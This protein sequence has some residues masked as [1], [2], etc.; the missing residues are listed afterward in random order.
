MSKNNNIEVE[1]LRDKKSYPIFIYNALIKAYFDALYEDESIKLE[2][3]G[4]EKIRDAYSKLYG[5]TELPEPNEIL[6]EL[7]KMRE[8]SAIPTLGRRHA[9]KR[10]EIRN[11]FMPNKTAFYRQS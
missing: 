11:L 4:V 10:Y 8:D 6:S 2:G 9:D 3:V 1:N 7:I 5:Y